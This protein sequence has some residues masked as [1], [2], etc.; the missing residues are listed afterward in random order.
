MISQSVDLWCIGS[1]L[2]KIR[3][4]LYFVK[5]KMPRSMFVLKKGVV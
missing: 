2:K 4:D 1:L 3:P 5:K